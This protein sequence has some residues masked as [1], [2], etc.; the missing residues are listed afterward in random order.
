MI[1]PRSRDDAANRFDALITEHH[2]GVIPMLPAM[3]INTGT[4]LLETLH[5]PLKTRFMKEIPC[6]NANASWADSMVC[7]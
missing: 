7:V 6:I 5:P 4:Y 2:I 1:V 3:D